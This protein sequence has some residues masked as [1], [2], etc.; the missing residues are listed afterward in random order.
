MGRE[1]MAKTTTSARARMKALDQA[2]RT[3]FGKL[4]AKPVSGRLKSLVDQL[5]AADQ[6]A[7]KK[8]G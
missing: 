4:E 2:L 1:P 5:D 3:M 7:K 8:V 6:P